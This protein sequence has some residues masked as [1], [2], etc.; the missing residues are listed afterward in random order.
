MCLLQVPEI[1]DWLKS[2]LSP[3]DRV[4]ADPKLVSADQ[5]LQWRTALG[6]FF[7]PQNI[8]RLIFQL[9]FFLFF[10]SLPKAESGI[11]LDAVQANLV[12]AIWNVDNGRPKPNPRP[13]YVHEV[14]YAGNL[15][16]F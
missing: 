14:V 4:G 12:D 3:G 11:Q 6:I 9:W 7:P 1:S 8:F 15:L 10:L 5:W 16:S 2:V 13:A